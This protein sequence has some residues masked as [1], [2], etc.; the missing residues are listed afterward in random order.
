MTDK[1]KLPSKN[2]KKMKKA[3]DIGAEDTFD[4]VE[5]RLI[6]TLMPGID[7]VIDDCI[8]DIWRKYD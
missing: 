8:A 7:T 6:E 5:Q 3:G 4:S 1:L 2:S